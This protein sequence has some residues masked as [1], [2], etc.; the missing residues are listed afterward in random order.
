MKLPA[1]QEIIS[2]AHAKGLYISAVI[3][4]KR[5]KVETKDFINR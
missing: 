1:F 3:V 2:Y 5:E 4:S